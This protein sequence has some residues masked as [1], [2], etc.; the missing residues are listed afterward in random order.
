MEKETERKK[1]GVTESFPFISMAAAQPSLLMGT[2]QND[3]FLS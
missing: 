1:N 2:V 3:I